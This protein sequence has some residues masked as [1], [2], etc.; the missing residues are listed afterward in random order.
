VRAVHSRVTFDHSGA[1]TEEMS[2]APFPD[3]DLV[4][5]ELLATEQNVPS[6][7]ANQVCVCAPVMRCVCVCCMM[8]WLRVHFVHTLS[9]ECCCALVGVRC[10]PKIVVVANELNDTSRAIS[11]CSVAIDVL[12]SEALLRRADDACN[13]HDGRRITRRCNIDCLCV[14]VVIEGTSERRATVAHTHL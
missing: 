9:L 11:L 3:A 6:L 8:R 5:Y 12:A 1:M 4:D 10:V 2:D 14:H 13:A 7:R